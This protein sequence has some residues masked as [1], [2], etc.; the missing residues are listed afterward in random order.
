MTAEAKGAAPTRKRDLP[1]RERPTL[2]SALL[3]SVLDRPT[4]QQGFADARLVTDWATI[5]G[6]DIARDSVPLKLDRR[7]RTLTLKVRPTAALVLQHSE[8]RINTFFG[9]TTALR[10]RLV[11]GPVANMTAAEPPPPLDPTERAEIER[12]VAEIEPAALRAAL[13][14]L[15]VALRARRRR[16][17]PPVPGA[18]RS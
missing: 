7:T 12:R 11:Q 9:A 6:A 18:A 8:P 2:A 5:A 15:G 10:L 17:A 14:D 13:V 1:R 3:A 4:R 16:D